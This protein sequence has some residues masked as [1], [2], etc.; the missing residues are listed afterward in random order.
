MIKAG[1]HDH[2]RLPAAVHD[3]ALRLGVKPGNEPA[4]VRLTQTGRMK[5]SLGEETWME[6]SATQTISTRVCEFNWR[7]TAGPFG[8]ISARDAVEHGE[9]RFDIMA[10]GIIPI[11]SAEHSSSLMRGELMRYLAELAWAPDAILHNTELR[12]RV[13]APDTLAVSAG[14]GDTRRKSC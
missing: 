7:A 9:G 3:L 13:D 10:L 14:S 2:T 4:N 5:R 8:L 6:F 1:K 12:W 11:A